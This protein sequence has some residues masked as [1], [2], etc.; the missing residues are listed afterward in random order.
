[1]SS[2]SAATTF[3]DYY[4]GGA[5]RAKLAQ[6]SFKCPVERCRQRRAARAASSVASRS[7]DLAVSS[8]SPTAVESP[9]AESPIDERVLAGPQLSMRDSVSS[10]SDS[11]DGDMGVMD[12]QSTG[13]FFLVP[14]QAQRPVHCGNPPAT[15]HMCKGGTT[16]QPCIWLEAYI[17]R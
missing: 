9:T 4:A 1:M 15:W 13:I 14:M 16:S 10:M 8:K 3:F 12:Q 7:D 17:H 5:C 6:C 11:Q 2:S